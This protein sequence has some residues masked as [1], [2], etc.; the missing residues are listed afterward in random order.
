MSYS[1]EFRYQVLDKIYVNTSIGPETV[2]TVAEW[3]YKEND[4]VYPWYQLQAEN[5]NKRWRLAWEIDVR[6]PH[7]IRTEGGGEPGEQ[8]PP[9]PPPCPNPPC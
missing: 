9:P 7:T 1:Y 6:V 3:Y 5:G 4:C 8:D 2:I